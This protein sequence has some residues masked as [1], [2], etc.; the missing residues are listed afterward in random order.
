MAVHDAACGSGGSFLDA[1]NHIEKSN[2]L[3]KHQKRTLNVKTL[4]E[5]TS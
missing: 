2:S 3:D 1:R 4:N 5:K